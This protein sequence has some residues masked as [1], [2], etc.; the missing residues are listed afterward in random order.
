MELKEALE[1]ATA[2]L[3]VRP[4]FVGDVMAG[5]RRRHTRKLLAITAAVALLAGVTTGVALTRSSPET[6]TAGDVR[7]T[8]ATAGDLA[9]RTDVIEQ[10]LTAWNGK[11]PV[12]VTEVSSDAHVFWTANTP[13]GP[14]ALIAQSV[15]VKASAEPQT[16]VGLVHG[17][18]V[19]DQEVV[20]RDGR[21]QGIY[22]IGDGE[23]TYVV[24]GLGERVFW[25]VNP[26]RGPDL[27]YSRAWQDAEIHDGVA[28]VRAKPAES[29]V[30]L[31]TTIAPAAD[32]FSRLGERISPRQ[33]IEQ[34]PPRTGLGWSSVLW[35]TSRQDPG[36]PG[37]SQD[38]LVSEDLRRRGYMDYG[39]PL[40]LWE[41]RAWLPDGRYAVV[42]ETNGDLIGALYQADGTFDRVLPGG[43]AVRGKPVP[44]RLVLPDGQGTIL[45]DR[46]A[47]LGPEEREGAWLAPPGTTEVT[48]W[49]SGDQ[50]VVPL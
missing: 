1:A 4:G 34:A 37:Q 5:A 16:L 10:A 2:D 26:V 12:P 28:V 13:D 14:A 17:T 38:K 21:E 47:L 41:V 24:L 6:F 46:N 7:L 15:R 43:P 42:T 35:A 49:R 39:H 9:D 33:E 19:V 30:F 44:V 8:A 29:P 32:D 18:E 45:A 48:I 36:K 22:R 3:D 11:R 31:R 40:V 23:A 25:S 27:R 50:V 20:Y